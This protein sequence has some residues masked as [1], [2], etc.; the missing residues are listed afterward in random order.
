[1]GGEPEGSAAKEARRIPSL[2][3]W[4]A[5]A[6]MMVVV[7]HAQLI[8]GALTLFSVTL[9][10]FLSGY[11]ITTLMLDELERTGSLDVGKFLVRRLLRL[12]PPLAVTLGLSYL[13]AHLGWISG[14][15]DPLGFASFL[16]YFHN[17]H[18][19]AGSA[20]DS[21]PLGLG[22]YWSLAVE[23]HFYLVFPAIVLVFR[24]TGRFARLPWF[25]ACLC[26]LVL[27]WRAYL[28]I[29]DQV[30]FG[31]VYYATDTRIDSILYG[32][33]LALWQRRAA[34]PPAGARGPLRDPW[35]AVGAVSLAV[36]FLVRDMGFRTVA[37]FT[38]QGLALMPLFL[39]SVRFPGHFLFAVL[40]HRIMVRLGELSYSVYLVHFVVILNIHRLVADRVAGLVLSVAII[41][42]Y[43]LAMERFLEKPLLAV[44]RR[45]R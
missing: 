36:S 45:W 31:R 8:P 25:L 42:A 26:A 17:Y 6:A 29:A 19:L 43:A 30:D 24:R 3:G 33:I 34:G 14:G 37:Q 15:T 11:L 1:M 4:R 44:R 16:L 35:L 39:C 21:V 13:L 9:F 40:N 20:P 5:V 32:C 10:F 7:G 23:Q 18:H 2:D 27:G 12:T 38:L 41:L 22:I 28:W